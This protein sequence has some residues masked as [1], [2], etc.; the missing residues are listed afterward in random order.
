MIAGYI[1]EIPDEKR[2]FEREIRPY[3]D[4]EQIKWIGPV[5]DEQRNVLLGN[6]SALLAP[7]EWLEPFPLILP[8]AYACG[9]P[10]LGFKSGGIT[11]GIENGVTGF[12][13]TTVDEMIADVHRIDQLSRKACREKAV[14]CYSD[15]KI[16]GDFLSVYNSIL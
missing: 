2:Y 10:V 3:I 5:D 13:S 7:V 1:S 9:T 16:A 14:A 15:E 8:E 11:E 12:L 6:A 4:G